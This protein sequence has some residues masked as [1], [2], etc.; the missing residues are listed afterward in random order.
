M[1]YSFIGT[2][3]PW[4][5]VK[6]APTKVEAP[7]GHINSTQFEVQFIL[8][9]KILNVHKK[10]PPSK[11]LRRWELPM[12]EHFD[13]ITKA[14]NRISIFDSKDKKNPLSQIK[15]GKKSQ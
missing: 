6:K 4:T 2:T 15:R 1:R 10:L 12:N 13:T 11:P 8:A 9:P 3:F 14:D 5:K 7:R